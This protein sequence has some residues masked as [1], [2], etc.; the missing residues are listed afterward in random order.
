MPSHLSKWYKNCTK[1][2][3]KFVTVSQ[4]FSLSLC[5]WLSNWLESSDWMATINRGVQLPNCYT[6]Q[7][8]PEERTGTVPLSARH[9]C[10][11]HIPLSLKLSCRLP[12]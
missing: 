10:Q 6:K 1:P 3:P 7:K 2:N 5:M 11:W 9:M 4:K 12:P 8:H